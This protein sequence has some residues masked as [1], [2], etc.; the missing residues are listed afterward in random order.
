MSQSIASYRI[1]NSFSKSPKTR[2][3]EVNFGGG[4]RQIIVDGLNAKEEVWQVEFI[5]YIN[6]TASGL[7]TILLN[8]TS[9]A[10]NFISWTPPGESTAKNYTAQDIQKQHIPPSWYV[11]SCS[12]RREF[13]L[14]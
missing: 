9:S 6:T 13:I 4:Y 5:P 8:S 14:S 2:S 12:L 11:V 7:E 3:R 1:T 10:S